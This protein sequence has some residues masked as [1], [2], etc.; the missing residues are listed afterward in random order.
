MRS[1][2]RARPWK[3]LLAALSVL[4]LV[5]SGTVYWLVRQEADR[6][7]TLAETPRV[8]APTSP[9]R[10]SAEAWARFARAVD[11]MP[12][13]T[14]SLSYALNAEGR[15]TDEGR[16][17]WSPFAPHIELL[18]AAL[19]ETDGLVY[20]QP[21]RPD[22]E[23]P[24]LRP[25]VTAARAW[26]LAAWSEAEVGAL[27]EAVTEMLL[28]QRLG[29]RFIEG[30][31]GLVGTMV[32]VAIE[33]LARRE[34][35]EL[36]QIYGSEHPELYES[37]A[38]GLQ[39]PQAG[40]AARALA[41]EASLMELF[42]VASGP[43][44]EPIV[45]WGYDEDVTRVWF[46]LR[47]QAEVDRAALPRHERPTDDLPLPWNT[48]SSS[49]GWLHNRSGRILLDVAT[50]NY[51]DVATREDAAIAGARLEQLRIAVRRY[52]LAHDGAI[53]SDQEAL[54]PAQL[55]APLVDPF[56]G[57]L[58]RLD[59]TAVWS[60]GEGLAPEGATLRLPL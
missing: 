1:P 18:R 34:L 27:S 2:S 9:A 26:L 33:G 37:A 8:H 60:V 11:H 44:T 16:D 21:S 30:D 3:A 5:A 39:V 54:V 23:P 24:P 40:F 12:A 57:Q 59:P 20:P 31:S 41:S 47:M 49:L 4:L 58:L 6:W 17:A 48:A 25:F 45:A 42:L 22:D 56:D 28:V 36:L 51:A 15:P 38:R 46:R 10:G 43:P 55:A 52:A 14:D 50:G 32:G 29:L 53:P 35:G 13:S 19:E 7:P